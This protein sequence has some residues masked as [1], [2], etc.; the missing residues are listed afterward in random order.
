MKSPRKTPQ[1]G[2]SS[3]A[4][5]KLINS[6]ASAKEEWSKLQ[7]KVN[8]QKKQLKELQQ[9][10]PSK[11]KSFASQ[12]SEEASKFDKLQSKL[13]RL[14]AQAEVQKK[15]LVETAQKRKEEAKST[16]KD[17]APRLAKL[18]TQ[19]AAQQLE[20][21][22]VG[23]THA[24]ESSLLGRSIACMEEGTAA[25]LNALECAHR[26]GGVDGGD[27][28]GVLDILVQRSQRLETSVVDM[29][30]D[31]ARATE[32]LQDAERMNQARRSARSGSRGAGPR[33]TAPTQ[34][35]ELT[36]E[37]T[38]LRERRKKAAAESMV[39][40]QQLAKA[41]EQARDDAMKVRGLVVVRGLLKGLLVC[42]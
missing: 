31:V 41:L 21:A 13:S 22:S 1:R 15:E 18:E 3:Q 9:K 23:A 35:G 38:T 11:D 29:E 36:D 40:L 33:R 17:L 32:R 8:E 26:G 34:M 14:E 20:L 19:Y 24:L 10:R 37:M 5:R 27:G 28:G 16:L 42:L 30:A 4:S 12:L 7:N 25:L 2:S 6:V 39:Q